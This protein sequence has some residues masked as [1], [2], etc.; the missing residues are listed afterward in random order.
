MPKALHTSNSPD[1]T[2]KLAAKF[3]KNLKAGD[4]VFLKGDLGAGKTVFTKGMAKAL[5]V[6][7]TSVVSPTFV[8]MNYYEG[9]LPLYHF[10]LYRLEKPE[11]I[12]SVQFDEY[13][14]GEGIS[15]VEWPERLGNL[16]PTEYWQVELT[17]KSETQRDICISYP[18]KP[19]QKI[20]L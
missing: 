6:N 5:K 18:S 1:E 2:M 4:I 17:H 14:Y 8:L 11:E 16:A 12:K 9:K 19:Q 3:V 20:S 10:D 7:E 13:F 15:I